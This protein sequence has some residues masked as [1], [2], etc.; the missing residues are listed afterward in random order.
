MNRSIE[1]IETIHTRKDFAVFLHELHQEHRDNP[2]AWE[3]NTLERFLE[4]LAAWT[5]DMDG[6]YLNQKQKLPEHLEW[7]TFAHM[8]V[9]ATM[10]E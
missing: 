7:K 4:A 5:E 2:Q 10:Y 9:A 3:N 8:L 1:Q 6:F